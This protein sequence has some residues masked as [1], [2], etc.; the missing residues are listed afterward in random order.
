MKNETLKVKIKKEREESNSQ[1]KKATSSSSKQK[2]FDLR[3][4]LINKVKSATEQELERQKSRLK[5]YKSGIL[6]NRGP[7]ERSPSINSISS[8]DSILSDNP[9][10]KKKRKKN[11]E[12][13][14][15]LEEEGKGNF[16]SS[17]EYLKSILLTS[18]L[19]SIDEKQSSMMPGMGAYP[20]YNPETG[21]WMGMYPYPPHFFPPIYPP[22]AMPYSNYSDMPPRGGYR[23]RYPRFRGRRPFR[24]RLNHYGNDDRR[25]DDWYDHKRRHHKR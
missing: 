3:N 19:G 16:Q 25:N 4:K 24:G 5:K 10:S 9:S 1:A 7:N 20:M 23:G 17:M 14:I 15:S 22:S 21:Q 13:D 6:L 11:D 2:G 8:D 18:Y 12:S